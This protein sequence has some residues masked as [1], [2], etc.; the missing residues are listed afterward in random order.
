MAKL[1]HKITT[2]NNEEN[3]QKIGFSLSTKLETNNKNQEKN[4]ENKTVT[5]STEIIKEQLI[6]LPILREKFIEKIGLNNFGTF[7]KAEIDKLFAENPEI[8][9]EVL[10]SKFVEKLITPE[11]IAVLEF[12][13]I[14]INEKHNELI[15]KA[16]KVKLEL[17]KKELHVKNLTQQ[18]TDSEEKIYLT[19][20][21][22]SNAIPVAD[23][24]TIFLT[25]K[26][27]N[28]YTQKLIELLTEAVVNE[29]ASGKKFTFSFLKGFA[30]VESAVLSLG[31]DEKENLDILYESGRKLLS[32][33]SDIFVAERRPLLDI[34]ANLF[35]SYLSTYDFISPEQTLQIDPQIHNAMGLGGGSV[36]EGISFA[37]VRR[38]T[39]KAV[40][41]AEIL[42][43]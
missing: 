18:V 28:Q 10:K 43:K 20:K 32:A 27:S 21:K 3:N 8:T 40:Y 4:N 39:R 2:D 35:N 14:E 6:K 12:L 15:T 42:T 9:D 24:L 34:I 38:E 29:G 37:V 30:F 7:K 1:S 26:I 17:E 36:K 11:L 22:F 33:I 23:I 13:S 31:G 16:E 41:Y 25:G 5:D 19:E